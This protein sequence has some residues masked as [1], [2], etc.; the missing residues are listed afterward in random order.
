MIY[1]DHNADT[2][3]DQRVLEVMLP[4]MGKWPG[5]PSGLH[6]LARLN[7]AAID[8]ARQQVAQLVQADPASVIFTSGG[9]EA[10]NLAIKGFGFALP[11]GALLIGA[12]EHP[13]VVEPAR[14]MQKL[15]WQLAVLPV[16][17]NG[18]L[19]T[20]QIPAKSFRYAS[21][22][23][24]NNETGVVSNISAISDKIRERG[25]LLHVDA[26]QTAGKI[27]LDFNQLGAHA[28]SVSAHKMN[29][30]SGV[31]ALIIDRT[32]PLQPLIHGGGQESGKRSGTENVAGIVG[33]GKAAELAQTELTQR[34]MD[35]LKLRTTLEKELVKIPGISIFGHKTDRLPN[36]SQFSIKGHHGESLIM[37]LDTMGFALSSGSACAS[38][39]GEP[40][41]T[42]SAMG[43]DAETATGAIRVS[44]GAGNTESEIDRFVKALIALTGTTP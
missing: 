33:F 34:N 32:T 12:T 3:I 27:P 31:G 23:H 20:D 10:N 37:Q 15:G 1:L 22:L 30:P 35:I 41:P 43:V 29:G 13:S 40:S 16:N 11:P 19:E 6:K 44:L 24:A 39:G 9:T 26:V 28:I 18:L 2:P 21:F 42:L 38:G 7:K 14:F 36:T 5:N 8:T 17:G 4:F 25:A